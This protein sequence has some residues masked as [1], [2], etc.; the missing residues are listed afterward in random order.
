MSSEIDSARFREALAMRGI[1]QTE[2][3]KRLGCTP[4]A[5]NQIASGRTRKSKLL[6]EITAE[7]QVSLDWLLRKTDDPSPGASDH[8]VSPEE[9]R[10]IELIR[11]LQPTDRTAV[12]QVTRSLADCM[13]TTAIIRRRSRPATVHDDQHTYKAEA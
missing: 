12:I 4:G 1:D 2:L 6:P 13:E 10:W 8:L 5:I 7:L 9:L 11:K 3:A